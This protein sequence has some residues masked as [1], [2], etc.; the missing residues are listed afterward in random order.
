MNVA[1]QRLLMKKSHIA[2]KVES[3]PALGFRGLVRNAGCDQMDEILAD[4][5]G[6]IRHNAESLDCLIFGTSQPR[7]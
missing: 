3:K 7:H 6:V 4:I 2:Y 5:T 1:T